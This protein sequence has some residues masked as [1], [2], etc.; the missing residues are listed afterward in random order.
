MG[1]CG[2]AGG[3][4]ELERCEQGFVWRLVREGSG[5]LVSRVAVCSHVVADDVV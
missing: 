4:D 5:R 2:F 3:F 1:V